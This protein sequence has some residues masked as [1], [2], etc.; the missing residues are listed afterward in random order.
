MIA[1]V[2]VSP[3]LASFSPG[4]GICVAH[5]RIESI[6][7][8]LPDGIEHCILRRKIAKLTEEAERKAATSRT[9]FYIRKEGAGQVA[10]VGLPN[11]GKSQLLA[12]VTDA[13][14]EIAEYPFTADEETR[15][16]AGVAACP[17]VAARPIQYR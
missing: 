4:I 6:C 14:P 15:D 16:K 8:Y 3:P 9:S 7:P 2:R 10:L 12:A 13:L 17:G 1:H 11:A 5:I